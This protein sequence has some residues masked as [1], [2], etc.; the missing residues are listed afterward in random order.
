MPSAAPPKLGLVVTGLG[1]TQIIG[2]GTTFYIP[3]V[4]AGRIVDDTGW[5]L[6][7]FVAA[8]SWCMLVSGLISKRLG[9]LLDRIGAR[10]VMSWGSVAL[11]AGLLVVAT[12]RHEVVLFLGWTIIGVGMRAA[13][14]DAAFTALAHM[15]GQRARRSISIVT[16]W[17]GLASTFFWPVGHLLGEAVGWRWAL[18]VYAVL[19]LL[20]CLPIHRR[21]PA[22]VPADAPS[23]SA[24]PVPAAP[25]AGV[26]AQREG[27]LQGSARDRAVVVLSVIFAGH[28]L[29][30]SGMSAH[31]MEL[32]TGLGLAAGVAVSLSTVIGV[33]QVGSR[34]LEMV[35]QNRLAPLGVGVGA[36]AMLVGALTIFWAA[37]PSASLIGLACV[38]YGAANGLITIVRGAL[39]LAV[40]GNLAY[41]E[42]LGRIAA[43]GLVCSALGPVLFAWVI[44]RIGTHPTFAVMVLIACGSF[45]G[46]V[47]IARASRGANPP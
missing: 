7:T 32:L 8:F 17:G 21:L 4:L 27:R 14:Y 10:R 47:W 1:V 30:W 35:A 19:N 24:P 40:F 37:S 15:A 42:T 2:W 39:P 13:L 44:E 22:H 31:M 46:M 43:P 38:V 18:V 29:V 5:T 45:G 9:G 36:M 26:A 33:A 25:A 34:L 11:A 16:L 28:A 3:A 20:C 23:S 12:A 6:T 41:G